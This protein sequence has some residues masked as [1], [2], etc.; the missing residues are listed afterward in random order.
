M[1]SP[2][3]RIRAPKD[4]HKRP[5]PRPDETLFG[6]DSRVSGTHATSELV[7]V[8]L[9]AGAG[10]ASTGYEQALGVN[11][12]VAVNHSP[13]AIET[14]TLN[15]PGTRH[16]LTDVFEVDPLEATGG[17]SVDLLH[18]SPD[19]TTYSSAKGAAPVR[20]KLRSL[21]WVA[22]R[23]LG[24]VRPRFMVMENV[25]EIMTDWGPLVARRD[26][27]GKAV[28]IP[29]VNDR[30]QPVTGP[31]GTPLLEQQLTNTRHPKKRN[32]HWKTFLAQIRRLGYHVEHRVLCAADY[33]AATTRE[34]L[35]IIAS[36]D[37]DVIPWPE[38]TH[39][40]PHDPRVQAGELLPWVGV[41]SA[42]DFS[43]PTR[44]VFGRA[45]PLADT[46]LRRVAQGLVRHH[47]KGEAYL[48]TANH[49]SVTF[50]GQSV[51]AP[52]ATIT[53][54]H[55]AHGLI[56]ALS[57][58]GG[59]VRAWPSDIISGSVDPKA[60][61]LTA[62]D[63]AALIL[64]VG[65]R[66][67]QCVPRNVNQPLYTTTTKADVALLQAPVNSGDH[68][69]DV[70]DLLCTHL[71]ADTLGALRASGHLHDETR[72]VRVMRAGQWETLRDLG[73]RM[74][75]AEE[76]KVAQSF[77]ASYAL[78]HADRREMSEKAKVRLIGNSVPPKYTRA[79]G[80]ALKS[81]ITQR[82]TDTPPAWL[83]ARR[84]PLPQAAD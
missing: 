27:T 31:D 33:G 45:R 49:G 74:L 72:E 3:P 77:P 55:D 35:F 5:A 39:A 66:A 25:S 38:Q 59:H 54:A 42:I 9:F 81:Q 43:V 2:H 47:L 26:A 60:A 57:S 73:L 80:L 63:A 52:M 23:W 1:T 40:A 14:H 67:G 30:G 82:G 28:M 65:G 6:L 32:R 64:G 22:L 17:R 53:A 24:T 7:I 10:G 83:A 16:Y 21:P 84:A 37:H 13:D 68:A 29:R 8:D 79:I 18:A 69:Q 12:S 76:L 75:N 48:I 15:H 44:S 71:D 46:T 61:G 19:C 20:R 4:R 51:A 34:R 70:Y 11:I 56:S 41:E 50:R 62:R 78:R 58:H 36:R